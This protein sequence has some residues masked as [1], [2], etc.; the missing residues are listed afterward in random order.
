MTAAEIRKIKIHRPDSFSEP[1]QDAMQEFQCAMLQE[2][3]A[4]LAELNTKICYLPARSLSPYNLGQRPGP[5][6]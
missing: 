2:I 6:G 4:H 3:A 1:T 5:R